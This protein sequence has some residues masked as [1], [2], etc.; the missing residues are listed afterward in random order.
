M[1]RP[2]LI[3]GSA[4]LTALAILAASLA[5][6][7]GLWLSQQ[8]FSP[9]PD[10]P[11]IEGLQGT[12]LYPQPRPIPAFALDGPA[13][14]QLGPEQLAGR[15][16]VVFVGF[17]HC[18]DICPTT[19]N[20][21]AQALKPFADEPPAGRPQVLF[22]SVDP[23][24][25]SADVAAEYAQFFDPGFLAATADHARLL[26]FTRSLGMVYMQTPIEGGGYTVDHSSS[27]AVI[28]PAGQL[29]A[30]IR[31]PL[32]PQHIAADLRRLMRSTP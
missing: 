7:L 2:T 25:D 22:V 14:A 26:P 10:A 16:N 3:A 31:P 24:R 20:L 30:V 18:P 9:T 6:G 1:T 8:S 23:E 32:V 27:L 11:R 19:L 21:L 13:G 29:V 12:L 5:A 4:K 15:W 28:D 17:T